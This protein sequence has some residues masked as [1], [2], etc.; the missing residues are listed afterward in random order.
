MQPFAMR[1]A[2]DLLRRVKAAGCVVISSATTAAEAAWL[3]QRGA[4]AVIA[5][6]YEADGHRGM[7]LTDDIAAQV[8]TFA[9]VPQIVD[10]VKVP[11]I[12]AVGIR[13]ARGF[14]AAFARGASGLQIG[15]G[16]LHCPEAK[17]S[18]PYRAALKSAHD[19]GTAITNL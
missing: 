3:E 11:V 7:F 5:Q 15:T 4:D 12:A 1:S 13:D 6:G 14:S 9:L 2:A 8:G 19:D 17:I 16:Y 10:V 18:A